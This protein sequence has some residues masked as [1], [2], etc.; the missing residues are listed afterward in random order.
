MPQGKRWA[1]A[2]ETSLAKA[3]L[4]AT[5]NPFHATDQTADAFQKDVIEKFKGFSP[6]LPKVGHYY[7]RSSM[8]GSMLQLLP[9]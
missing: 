2:E 4:A 6:E 1:F 8:E 3:F 7:H 9:P 5:Q